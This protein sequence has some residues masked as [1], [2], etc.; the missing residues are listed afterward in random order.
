MSMRHVRQRALKKKCL[1]IEAFLK[2][3]RL[4]KID[5]VILQATRSISPG[6]SSKI[7]LGET[8]QKKKNKSR[9]L[10]KELGISATGK[11]KRKGRSR[12]PVE[13]MSDNL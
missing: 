6:E 7:N 2:K 13:V 11:E 4:P 3:D 1:D 5:R 12:P 8:V 9:A 10:Y